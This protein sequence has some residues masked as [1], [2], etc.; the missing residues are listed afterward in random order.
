MGVSRAVLGTPDRIA[1]PVRRSDFSSAPAAQAWTEFVS[2][3]RIDRETKWL[4]RASL[5]GE[6]KPERREGKYAIANSP[7]ARQR[8]AGRL[9]SVACYQRP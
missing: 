2:I 8:V 3:A 6:T 1:D 9:L 5:P 4:R 7:I